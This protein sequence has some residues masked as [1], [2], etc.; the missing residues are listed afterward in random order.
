MSTIDWGWDSPQSGLEDYN[1]EF[2]TDFG[3]E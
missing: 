3:W 2:R 1:W